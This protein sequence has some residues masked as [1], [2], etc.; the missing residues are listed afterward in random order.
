MLFDRSSLRRAVGLY[1]EKDN[2]GADNTEDSTE[3][4]SKSKETDESK[5]GD[6]KGKAKKEEKLFTQAELDAHIEDRL[7]RE[8][9]KNED[10]TAK[11]KKD[12]EDAALAK[13]QEW[14]K[15]AETRATE[16]ADLAKQKAELEPFKEQAEKY[17]A[18]LDKQ[19]AERKKSLPKFILPLIEKMDPVEAMDYITEHAEELGGAPETYSET[20]KG[21]E[22]KVS[23]DDK[24]AAEKAVSTVITRSF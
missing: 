2:G 6:D 21:K 20:P 9:K 10:A 23:E 18:V 22:K 19:L 16:I 3:D 11:A 7:K 13:N 12:A 24:K 8:R 17:K 14:Q 15:L 1:F 5:A 4:E